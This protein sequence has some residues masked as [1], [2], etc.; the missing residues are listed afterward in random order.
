MGN[1]F[2]GKYRFQYLNIP[3]IESWLSEAKLSLKLCRNSLPEFII[4]QT[5]KSV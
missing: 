3:G 1:N 2:G 4:I 5:F